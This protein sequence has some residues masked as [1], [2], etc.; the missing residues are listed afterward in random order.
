MG[1]VGIVVRDENPQRARMR[2]DSDGADDCIAKL[3]CRGF[4]PVGAYRPGA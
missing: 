4:L 3:D 2:L 1:S